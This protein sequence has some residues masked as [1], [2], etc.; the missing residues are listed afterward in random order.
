MSQHAFL[1]EPTRDILSEG[2]FHKVMVFFH[3]PTAWPRGLM[4]LA[5]LSLATVAGGIWW[6]VSANWQLALVV[7]IV[8]MG[9]YLADSAVLHTLPNKGISFGPWRAQFFPLALPRTA[10]TVLFSLAG[11][12]LGW[13]WG[14]ALVLFAQLAG[15]LL[16]IRGAVVEPARLEMT[17]LTVKSHRLLSGTPPIRLLH[18]SD[19]HIEQLSCRETAILRAIKQAQPDV[20]VLTGDYVNTSYNRNPETYRQIR[21]FLGQLSAPYGVYATLGT[22]P[23]DLREWV[24][25]LFDGLPVRLMREAWQKIDLGKGRQLV[26]LGLDCTH[27]I[28]FDAARLAR[29]L[30]MAPNK[31][32]QVLLY[33]SP[34]LA[35][36]AIEGEIDLYLCGHTHGGQVRLPLIGPLIT[37]SQLGRRYVMGLYRNGR[38]HIYV[39]RGVGLEGLSA[40]R[41]RL[42]APPEIT[43]VTIRPA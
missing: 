1:K 43:L 24:L 39:T 38:T 3:H 37:S 8:Q 6:L 18:I 16:L 15:T 40:P 14:I 32:P 20:I 23:V 21:Q 10:L 4:A 33:H 36:Q 17:R 26:L 19:L 35:P 12:G 28:P 2:F 25:P 7:G 42:L 29:I 11:L 27:D 13:G 9:F 41:V 31:A 34:E 30:K 5:I 22:P